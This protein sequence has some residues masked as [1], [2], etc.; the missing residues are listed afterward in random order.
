MG[1]TLRGAVREVGGRGLGWAGAGGGKATRPTE[2]SAGR[3]RGLAV[4]LVVHQLVA[5]G[6][7]RYHHS[8]R[9][10]R[11]WDGMARIEAEVAG[12]VRGRIGGDTA[13]PG[14]QGVAGNQGR[15]G[16]S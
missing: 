15:S 12:G 10:G 3:G 9:P 5:P 13:G 14:H 6:A 7:A 16:R 4:G 2:G 1:C 11:L 8:F